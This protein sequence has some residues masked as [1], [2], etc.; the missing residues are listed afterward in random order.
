MCFSA[1]TAQPPSSGLIE[2]LSESELEVLRLL[3]E[4]LSN[5]EIAERMV[6]AVGTVKTHLHNVYGKLG[7]QNRAQAIIKAQELNLV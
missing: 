3:M 5:R 1:S 2:P 7:V 6:V 4:G